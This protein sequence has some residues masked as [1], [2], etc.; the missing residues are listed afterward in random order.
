M[1]KTTYNIW[2]SPDL[3][4]KNEL[5]YNKAFLMS[6]N[7]NYFFISAIFGKDKKKK[8]VALPSMNT[9]IYLKSWSKY[10]RVF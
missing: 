4:E 3:W 6:F 2:C 9:L 7:Y 10:S 5:V 8:Y 1:V